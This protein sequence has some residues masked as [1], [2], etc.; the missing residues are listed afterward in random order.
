[1][2]LRKKINRIESYYI[3]GK[4]Y[5]EGH[6]VKKDIKKG[7][8]YLSI[9]ADQNSAEANFELGRLYKEGKGVRRNIK[10]ANDYLES[11]A[12]LGSEQAKNYLLEN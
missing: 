12:S 10:K 3:L 8:N 2:L 6:L 1:M 11:A 7:M 5:V 4:A 9:A